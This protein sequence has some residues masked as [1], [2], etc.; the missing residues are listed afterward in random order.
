MRGLI[1]KDV[2]IFFKYN[3]KK[4][5][6]ILAGVLTLLMYTIG[7]DSGL[8]ASIMLSVMVGMQNV[9]IFA[10]DEKAHWKRYQLA[11]PVRGALVVVSKYISVICTLAFSVLGSL[12]INFLCSV[13]FQSFDLRVWGLS[14]ALAIVLPL[15]W[16]GLCIPLTYWFGFQSAQIVR[17]LVV[18]P[19]VY[20][21]NYF[22]DGPG[23]SVMPGA[24][25][26]IAV[27]VFLFTFV[28]FCISAVIS[29]V[30]YERRK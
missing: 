13:V 15:V 2:S 24:L 8:M 28:F 29:I 20:L 23:L 3:D 12:V 9:V 26:S 6:L 27:T 18:F 10:S 1:Y 7:A 5:L 22:E 25:S 16:A 17:L 21:L 30:G 19:L 14:V 11:L 4:T